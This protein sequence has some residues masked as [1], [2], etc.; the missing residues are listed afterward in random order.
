MKDGS[1]GNKDP[2]A[3]AAGAFEPT[4]DDPDVPPPRPPLPNPP[5]GLGAELPVDPGVEAAA[6]LA[7][8]N[9]PNEANED[10]ALGGS[11]VPV[12]VVAVDED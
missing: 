10:G 5:N 7:A 4:V 1:R 8:P 9:P 3:G 12:E 11:E 2:A 6:G